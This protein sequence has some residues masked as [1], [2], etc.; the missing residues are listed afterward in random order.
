MIGEGVSRRGFLEVGG[1]VTAASLALTTSSAAA[2]MQSGNGARAVGQ[3]MPSDVE[4]PATPPR[5][6]RTDSVGFAIVGLGDYALK[7]MMPRFAQAERAH[8][9]ALV[10]GNPE[11]LSRVGDAYAIRDGH[12]RVSVALARGAATID[13]S[14]V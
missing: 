2:L 6:E 14:L 3:E 12:H 7:Q 10:S 5:R 4:L 1:G 8:I 9:A 13:A 11:K